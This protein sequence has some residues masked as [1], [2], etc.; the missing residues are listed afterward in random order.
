MTTKLRKCLLA[1]AIAVS[2]CSLS[3]TAAAYHCRV[4]DGYW[5]HG[6]YHHPHRVCWG[7]DYQRRCG[8]RNGH[9]V[10]W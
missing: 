5:S 8:W 2:L 9:R 10:C 3:G 6:Y 4:T 1:L 7:G